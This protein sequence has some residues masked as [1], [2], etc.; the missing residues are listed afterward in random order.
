MKK[1]ILALVVAL[2][3]AVTMLPAAGLAAD[4]V[5]SGT[6]YGVTWSIDSDGVM[7]LSGYGGYVSYS[8][9][10]SYDR[11]GNGHYYN[12]GY[13]YVD[14][15][16]NE[17]VNNNKYDFP[18]NAWFDYRNQVKKA[19]IASGTS[20]IDSD[21]FYGMKNLTSVSIPY[22]VK[23][24]GTAAFSG[25]ESLSEVEIPDAVTVINGYTF[26]KCKNLEKVVIPPEVTTIY[27][28]SFSGCESLASID[29][30]SEVTFIGAYTFNNCS[31][32]KSIKIPDGVSRILEYTFYNCTSL[33]SVS[34]PEGV[35]EIGQ[36]TF[37]NCTSLPSITMP[38]SVTYIGQYA[39]YGCEALESIDI[40]SGVTSIQNN[41]FQMCPNLKSIT[42]P[43]SVTSIGDSAFNGCSALTDVY[44]YGTEEDWNNISFG[45]SNT[46]LKNATVHYIAPKPVDITNIEFKNG[47]VSL[48]WDAVPFA[49]GYS[50]SQKTDA[51]KWQVIADNITATNYTISDPEENTTQ[52]YTVRSIV[53][54]EYSEGYD[55]TAES[56]NVPYYIPKQVTISS[57]T[58]KN[59]AASLSWNAAAGAESYAVYKKS[60]GSRWT[61]LEKNI[62]K[63]TYTDA[64]VVEGAEYS[65]TVRSM[66]DG[67][68][69]SDYDETAQ[70]IT[71]P[72]TPKPVRIDSISINAGKVTV[73]W[74]GIEGMDGY[75]L[76][77]KTDSTSWTLAANV[78]DTTY[79]DTK[80]KEGELNYYTVRSVVGSA[81]STG[82]DDTAASVAV[83]YAPKSVKID[84][85]TLNG[86]T[87]ALAWSAT[88]G[89]EG[90]RIFRKTESGSWITLVS[91]QNAT[92]YTDATLSEG[93]TYYY[94]VSSV[95]DGE[96]SGDKANV[97]EGVSVGYTAKPVN[98]D[99]IEI[100]GGN[101]SITWNAM[102]GASAYSVSR[103]LEGGSWSVVANNLTAAE[104]TDTNAKE[105]KTYY[106]AVR[107]IVNGVYST[108]Y[109][110][111]AESIYVPYLPKAASITSINANDGK[112]SFTW[113]ALEGA[114]GYRISRKAEGGAWTLLSSREIGTSYTDSA[115]SE[116]KTYYYFV[117]SIVD[118]D[119][120]TDYT[121]AV[122]ITVSYTVRPVSIK[123][124]STADGKVTVSWNAVSGAEGYRIHRRLAGGSWT[125][126]VSNTTATTYTDTSVKEGKTY[127]YTV[128]SCINGV[129]STGYTDTAESIT[130]PYEPVAVTI[131]DIE[132]ANGKVTL[133]WNGAT[134]MDGYRIYRKLGTGKWTILVSGTAATSYT[135]S[136]V[137]EGKTYTYAVRSYVGNK[138]STDYEANAKSITAAVPVEPAKVKIN[139]ITYNNGAVSLS[140][141]A[142]D[143]VDGYRI[144]RKLGTGKWTVLVSST[145]ATSYTDNTVT[146]GKTYS[147]T[148][149]SYV[150]SKYSTDYETTA[151]TIKAMPPAEAL[152]VTINNIKYEN[153]KV[154]L[155]WDPVYGV[156]GYR[157]YRKLGTGKWTIL[158]SSTAGTTYTD[159]S[160]TE[161]KTYSYTIRSYVGSNYSTGYDATAETITAAV[162]VEPAPVTINNITYN[163]G[164]VSLS[165]DAID[166]VD[167]YRIYRKLGTGKWTILVSS[168][169]GTTYIDNTVTEGKTYSYTLRSYVG[170]SYSTGYDA[171]AETIKAAALAEPVPVTINNIS[172]DNGAVV[173]SWNAV[174]GMDGYRIY[175]KVGTGKWTI[176]VS[177]TTATNY[178]DNTVTEGKT[179]SYT[180]RSYVGSSY[181]TGYDATAETIKAAALA[182]PMPVTINEIKYDNGAVSLSWDD[183]DGMDGYRIYRKLGTGKWTI[184]VSDTTA[185]TY[186]DNTVTEGKTY[187]YT[188]RSHLGNSYSTGYEDT[189]KTIKA[190]SLA[191]P[192]PVT[193]NEIKYDNGAVTL[194]WDDVDGMDGYRIYRKL[195]TGKWTILVS[196][197]TATTYTDN[198]VTEGKTYSYTLRSHVG[199]SYSTGYED[200]AKT[201]K[202][203]SLAE[204]LPVTINEIKYD[205][206]AVVLSWDE[207][208]G[209]DGYRIYRKLGT[210]KWTI[211]VS[212]TTATTY[213]D[214]TVTAG[215][216]YSYT[217]RSHVG[218]SYSTGYEDTA[219]TIKAASLAEPL[220]VTIN[221][222]SVVD[223]AVELSW[224]AIDGVDG[225][226]IYR[227]LG[228]GKWTVI[229]S[230]TTDTSYTDDTVTAGK[231]YSY[232]LRSY[233]GNNYSTGYE[234]TQK[235]ITVEGS[236]ATE[237]LIF[238]TTT[239]TVTGIE[240]DTITALVIPKTIDGVYVTSIGDYAFQSCGSLSSVDIAEGVTSIGRNAFEYCKSLTRV[241]IP[242][243]MTSIGGDAFRECSNLESIVIPESVTRL[244]YGAL[245]GCGSLESVVIPER[246]TSIEQWEFS[247]CRS[248]SSVVIPAGVTSI[249][250]YAF[251]HCSS[252]TD[253]YFGGTEEDWAAIS[254]G[255]SNE[256]LF[257]ATI[258]CAGTSGI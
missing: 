27:R 241:V 229:V 175:R 104:Y 100:A 36:Y 40:P 164:A 51:G 186:A 63:T 136:T 222:I 84:S 133:S 114:E 107:S 252:L 110:N 193:I 188:L 29:I 251:E 95:V 165:W 232:T 157:I 183:V 97:S 89:A 103:K 11:L 56:V 134:G 256:Y 138:Y 172:Y 23:T 205:N 122:N 41:T 224:D 150:G 60:G 208:D 2:L 221:E 242:K 72:Y 178:A 170:S 37:Y 92:S 68:Y 238:D 82:Y 240:D 212:D 139:N 161:G 102:P 49:E 76:Y 173:F 8:G 197:T 210:G 7:N 121:Q 235:S 258:H 79:T 163:N 83:P 234:D 57:L 105:G 39:F 53:N 209:M 206:G 248:L 25:C 141:N 22:S 190:A 109:E 126:L 1:I 34:I 144:Y 152:P 200:T 127:E 106:Y 182:E 74:S 75:R 174:E 69:S 143:G 15:Y 180:V 12:W 145:T 257:E 64:D 14:Q 154:S 153:G 169:T 111:T 216:T 67:A 17:R 94:A 147:Y 218:N 16:G 73:S 65:Y 230:S 120:N 168:T 167:G 228:T 52:T 231:T 181:S 140:W 246:V 201:I 87:A 132:Y 58:V 78:T 245:S 30:P 135:D 32:L 156:D 195:G 179:Y 237:G 91:S 215:K 213:R 96:D 225:Y 207:V 192:V 184:L 236:A 171:T 189:A 42:L 119:Y 6:S 85:V 243:S 254:V 62:T 44:Y 48:S 219:E 93:E 5:A 176:L 108:G 50:I 71:I 45:S 26:Y 214:D 149:R 98:I 137:T 115:V 185:T 4:V 13:R 116:G 130:V 90:Y 199:N 47:G 31:S 191:E 177:N 146:E 28:S 54:G 227:K 159:N 9:S 101:V 194:S 21:D 223:G 239:G 20:G 187:S 99:T 81:L 203:A 233:V 38:R 46:R 33:E 196:D 198:T 250:S 253:V 3:M 19:V 35:T 80:A 123:S 226:R 162:P 148:L 43:K 129:Y 155:S 117:S 55:A 158:L 244:D 160:V 128:R 125:T 86:K 255:S 24:I 131:N 77:R 211:L 166:G 112:V 220:P 10:Y 66:I 217:L 124:I 113:S 88:A 204:P 59:G 118:G 18:E 61:L 247:G 249:G 142:Q 202:A 151:E 70:S